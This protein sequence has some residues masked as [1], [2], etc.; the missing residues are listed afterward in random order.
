MR[1][2]LDQLRMQITMLQSQLSRRTSEVPAQSMASVPAPKAGEV[3]KWNLHYS[4]SKSESVFGFLESVKDK[5]QSR[6]VNDSLLFKCASDL[7]TRPAL[8]WYRSGLERNSFSTWNEL[9]SQL[10]STFLP[11]DWEDILLD[12][13]K[14]RKQGPDESI[15]IYVACVTKMFS[16]LPSPPGQMA[17]LK[18]MWK[19]LHLFYLER[20]ELLALN[21][22]SDLLEK[23]RV[24]EYARQ[25]TESRKNV[26]IKPALIDPDLAY[27][28]NP[29]KK[30]EPKVGVIDTPKVE[31]KKDKLTMC[32]NCRKPSNHLGQDCPLPKQK[33]CYKCGQQGVIT[34]DCPKCSKN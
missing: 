10:K 20:I 31:T 11:Q 16:R 19:N 8:I 14:T 32:W 5:A 24:V 1:E 23:G 3:H 7:F 17:Q 29:R 30:Y 28:G 33:Y 22:V 34:R 12:E 6:N 2:E 18:I 15:E 26:E 21:T 4:G 9:V 25:V 27:K 13:I